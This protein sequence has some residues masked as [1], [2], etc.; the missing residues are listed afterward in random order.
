M[1]SMGKEGLDM[2]RY[3]V[4]TRILGVLLLAFSATLVAADVFVH[5]PESSTAPGEWESPYP[6]PRNATIDFATDPSTWPEDPTLFVGKD[7]I[8]GVNYEIHG[9]DDDSLHNSLYPPE[10]WGMGSDGLSVAYPSAPVWHSDDPKG[11]SR[12]GV[13]EYQGSGD[14]YL[15]FAN[16]PR[17]VLPKHIWIETIM[18]PPPGG[19]YHQNLQ[20]I[21]GPELAYRWNGPELRFSDELGDGWVSDTWYIEIVPSPAFELITWTFSSPGSWY[22]DEIHIATEAVPEPGTIALFGLG[23]LGL[24]ARLRRLQVAPNRTGGP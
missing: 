17:D 21:G 6:Y 13:I 8:P 7:L 24:A 1:V 5:P 9:W 19:T 10:F 18:R 3:R 2:S 23:L 22:I 16:S 20:L 15:Y 4:V 12:T 14:I 11:S